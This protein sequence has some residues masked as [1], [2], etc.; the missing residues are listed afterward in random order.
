MRLRAVLLCAGL[1]ATTSSA[2]ALAVPIDQQSRSVTSPPASPD[3]PDRIV[4]E[5]PPWHV[6][7]GRTLLLDARL[8][9]SSLPNGAAAETYLFASITAADALAKAPPVDLAI[10][11]DRSGSMKG[12]RIGNAIAAAVGAVDRMRDGD[13]IV[14]VSFDTEA[15]VVVP[16]TVVSSTTRS[17]VESAIRSIRLGGDT[18]ISCGLEEARRQLDAAQAGPT[19]VARALLLSDG[20]TNHG[21]TDVPGLRSLAGRM[22]DR[23]RAISTIGVDLDFDEKV[24]SALAIESN[25]N[26][27]FVGDAAALPSVFNKEFDTLVA[28]MARDADVVIEPAPGVEIEEVFD[29]PAKRQG[30]GVVIPLGSF[31]ARDEKS[32][33]VKL[34][35]PADRDG[36]RPV[37]E[38]KLVY[39]DL[40]EHADQ[41]WPAT[42]SLA[43]KS[44]GTAQAEL[45]PFVRARVERS[46]TAKALAQAN[47]LINQGR[48]AEARASIAGRSA[49]LKNAQAAVNRQP[50]PSAPAPIRARGFKKDFEDQQDALDRA[51]K[52]AGSAATAAPSSRAVKEAPK[53]IAEDLA[54]NPFR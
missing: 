33:L 46:T 1:G 15:Q 31:S 8:G 6:N 50:K 47:E 7:I 2:V 54:G 37:V 41:Q 13:R 28:T 4:A 26:H 11:V 36:S 16:L 44:D 19:R 51:D 3:S 42:L 29:R 27:Y 43:V 24:M 9:H 49:D 22:R 12:A 25:G 20:A 52:V 35:V 34:R 39:H 40:V 18:C 53:H 17:S 32:A 5:S 14:V 45:D 23:G 10:V 30:S 48:F 38:M 21:I